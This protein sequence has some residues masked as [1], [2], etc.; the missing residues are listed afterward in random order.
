MVV[1]VGFS[2]PRFPLLGVA[3][4][5]SPLFSKISVAQ[6]FADKFLSAL[7]S[8]KPSSGHQRL[9]QN[10]IVTFGQSFSFLIGLILR[11]PPRTFQA[12]SHRHLPPRATVTNRLNLLRPSSDRSFGFPPQTDSPS[13]QPTSVPLQQPILVPSQQPIIGSVAAAN[14]RFR[15]SSQ[16][17]V[18]S[19]QPTSKPSTLR[20]AEI[21]WLPP[22]NLSSIAV[23]NLGSFA[24]A[25]LGSFAVTNLS[26]FAAANLS[27]VTAANS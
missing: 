19:P 4:K 26:S 12:S 5:Y 7:P 16:L 6:Y 20:H 10:T 25:N 14:Y 2:K 17:S 11:R 27:S 13:Q 23:A 9:P 24:A 1:C 22:A 15:R 8:A 18:P 21:L 3:L